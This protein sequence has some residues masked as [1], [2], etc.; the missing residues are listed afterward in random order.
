MEIFESPTDKRII[1]TYLNQDSFLFGQRE[2]TIICDNNIVLLN[3]RSTLGRGIFT[4]NKQI[5]FFRCDIGNFINQL[6]YR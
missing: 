1:T 3:I 6:P 2:M 4:S 5:D